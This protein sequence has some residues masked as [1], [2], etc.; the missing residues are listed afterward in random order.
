MV[1]VLINRPPKHSPEASA[2]LRVVLV[3]VQKVLILVVRVVFN[4][5]PCDAIFSLLF[6][7][8][9]AAFKR[10]QARCSP[11]GYH[12]VLNLV[13]LVFVLWCFGRCAILFLVN[14][15]HLETVS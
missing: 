14:W 4:L 12:L 11:L 10:Q 6:R 15:I 7:V 9:K 5:E 13:E 2:V 1:I 3:A 8:S